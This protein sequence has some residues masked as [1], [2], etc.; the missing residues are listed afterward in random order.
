M[1]S[2]VATKPAPRA[3]RRKRVVHMLYLAQPAAQLLALVAVLFAFGRC[4][5]L[6][7]SEDRLQKT[8]ADG[9]VS[10][11][12]TVTPEQGTEDDI[13]RALVEASDSAEIPVLTVK[14]YSRRVSDSLYADKKFET[15]DVESLFETRASIP[16]SKRKGLPLLSLVL[17]Q[18]QRAKLLDQ[19]L[20]R[21]NLAE[22]LAHSKTKT[23]ART[24]LFREL[25]KIHELNA[26]PYLVVDADAAQKG[27]L[28]FGLHLKIS[29]AF[30]SDDQV[31]LQIE[32][33]PDADLDA[34]QDDLR[35][36]LLD[37][38]GLA[39]VLH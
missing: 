31:Y 34:Q 24:A 16:P 4:S 36:A 20:L 25:R 38:A 10:T 12:S 8:S 37:A 39:V 22:A 6:A 30:L 26:E 15:D 14:Q 5:P 11:V 1:Q 28:T 32:R 9:V 33:V 18:E 29:I 13:T 23:D 35:S 3:P 2:H 19:N 17:S 21:L 7:P 27:A